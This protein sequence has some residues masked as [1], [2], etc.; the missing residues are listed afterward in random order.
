MAAVGAATVEKLVAVAAVMATVVVAMIVIVIYCS[1]Y[2][3]LL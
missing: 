3:I 1:G 2:I